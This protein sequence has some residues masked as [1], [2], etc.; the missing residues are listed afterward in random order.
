MK[1]RKARKKSK[2]EGRTLKEKLRAFWYRLFHR[3]KMNHNT[4]LAPVASVEE[5]EVS[6]SPSTP[7]PLNEDEG[8]FFLM[9]RSES[10]LSSREGSQ[11]PMPIRERQKY[12]I[13]FVPAEILIL[14]LGKLS[15]PQDLLNCM[16]VSRGW[17]RCAVDLLW[18]RPLFTSW[19]RLGI[20]AASITKTGS[21]WLYQDMIR[22]LNLSNLSEEINDGTLA[23]F[24]GCKRIE[25]LTL[26]GCGKLTDHGVKLLVEGNQNLLALDVTGVTALTDSTIESL[27]QNCPR[28]QGLNITGCRN[29]TDSSLVPLAESCKYL[30]RVCMK[31]FTWSIN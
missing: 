2:P 17:A 11:Q 18:H 22:R 8:D 20:I 16:Q 31:G 14:I 28:L 4:Y 26:T 23:P 12:P 3:R 25:R 21:Y 6:S 5:S 29:I 15:S 24:I 19:E 9:Q 1:S 30:K 13:D 10:P 27:A 7:G